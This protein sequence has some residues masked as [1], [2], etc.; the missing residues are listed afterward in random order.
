MPLVKGA[1]GLQVIA[2]CPGD[3]IFVAV[4]AFLSVS[5]LPSP[6]FISL[7]LWGYVSVSFNQVESQSRYCELPLKVHLK[8]FGVASPNLYIDFCLLSCCGFLASSRNQESGRGR[9]NVGAW[10]RLTVGFVGRG[11]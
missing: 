8:D 3:C 11:Q 7:S 9:G 2:P 6:L 5:L 1:H 10:V 4:S